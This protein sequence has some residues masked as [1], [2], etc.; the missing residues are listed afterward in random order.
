MILQK[1][2]MEYRNLF[3]LIVP[4]YEKLKNH[5]LLKEL[6]KTWTLSFQKCE[7]QQKLANTSNKF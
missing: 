7:Q 3:F 5:N 6:H 2:L 1:F 4:S